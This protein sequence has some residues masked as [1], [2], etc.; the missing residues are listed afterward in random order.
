MTNARCGTVHDESL[1]A[2]FRDCH[3]AKTARERLQ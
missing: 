2:I 1:Q 3:A